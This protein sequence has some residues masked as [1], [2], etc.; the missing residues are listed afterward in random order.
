M[1]GQQKSL[2]DLPPDTKGPHTSRLGIIA[3]VATFG[4]LLFG[5]DTGVVNGALEPLTQD[6]GLTPRT[7]GLVVSFLTIGAAFGAV[8]G[9][10]LSD[11]SAG[12]R[13]SFCSRCSSSSALWHAPWPRTGSSSPVP[14]SSSA[15]QSVPHRRPSPSTCRTRPVRTTWVAR[16][17]Q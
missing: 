16:H 13:T 5:Y 15:S 1:S 12:G 17:T 2:V 11:A 10:R 14:A 8:I 3:V 7:E 4:G 9:G 6:F